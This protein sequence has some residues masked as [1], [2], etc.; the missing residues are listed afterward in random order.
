[1]RKCCNSKSENGKMAITAVALQD[2]ISRSLLRRLSLSDPVRDRLRVKGPGQRPCQRNRHENS[3]PQH[4][5]S[6]RSLDGREYVL[7]PAPPPLTLAQK[8]G[9]VETPRRRLSEAE[10]EQVKSRSVQEGDNT[11]PCVICKE[12]FC[13]Q[14]QV[15]LSC[16]HVFH[17]ACLKAFERYSGKKCCPMCRREQYETR[18]IHEG[19]RIYREKCVI[20]I[21]AW[22][23]GCVARR[24][25]R[26]VRRSVPPKDKRLR[27]RFFETKLQEMS[28]S[29]VQACHTDTEAFLIDIEHSVAQS[30]LIFRQLETKC[31]PGA[32]ALDWELVK[33]QAVQREMQD[34]PICLTPLCPPCSGPD[35][36]R[37]GPR[38]GRVTRHVLLLSCSHLFHQPCLEAFELFCPETRPTCPLC[39]AAYSKRVL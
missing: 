7:D 20:R 21:Q 24:W 10:W 22:W 37:P 11:Q 38:R 15:L 2:H 27:Q 9:L 35:G 1:M 32:Q 18:V 39:R 19:A 4:S 36:H 30:R 26:N 8:L 16:T 34:C 28:D 17:K 25:Y 33:E 14:P 13:L 23:R 5:L 31:A 6:Q 29:L 12:E 3:K